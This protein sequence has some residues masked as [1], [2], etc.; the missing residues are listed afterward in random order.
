MMDR[1]Q[2]DVIDVCMSK[3]I[4]RQYDDDDDDDDDMQ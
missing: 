2:S 1:D 4:Y 3:V